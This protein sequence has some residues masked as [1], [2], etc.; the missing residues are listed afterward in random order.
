MLRVRDYG[1]GDVNERKPHWEGEVIISIHMDAFSFA[2][3][4][5][6]QIFGMFGNP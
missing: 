6:T 4:A 2:A 1:Q 5:V 3:S